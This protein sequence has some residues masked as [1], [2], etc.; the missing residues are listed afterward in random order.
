MHLISHA[1]LDHLTCI[2]LQLFWSFV[3]YWKIQGVSQ[4]SVYV[5]K[6]INSKEHNLII[7][8]HMFPIQVITSTSSNQLFGV[9]TNIFM[10][11]SYFHDW[12]FKC[13]AKAQGDIL[14][15]LVFSAQESKTQKYSFYYHIRQREKAHQHKWEAKQ[16]TIWH[17][18][19]KK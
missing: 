3:K 18:S 9:G 10:I 12:S 16:K 4:D 2:W 8:K 5:K 11:E 13:Y 19:L 14:K 17:F 15:L 1:A 7:C 6:L